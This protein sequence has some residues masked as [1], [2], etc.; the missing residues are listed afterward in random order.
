[1]TTLL[2]VR[3]GG[4]TGGGAD[5]QLEVHNRQ[6]TVRC[7]P[8]EVPFRPARTTPRPVVSGFVHAQ[9]DG[10]VD[11]SPRLS[12]RAGATRCCSLG[13]WSSRAAPRH[14]GFAWPSPTPDRAMVTHLPLHCGAEVLLA[15]MDGDVDRLVIIGLGN[16]AR[17][18]GDRQQRYAEHHPDAGGDIVIRMDDDV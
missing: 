17:V 6:N 4:A 13:T 14:G 5:A 2:V 15:H 18:P 12:T 3:R 8:A 10:E 7:I 16:E 11:G 9:I 1:M